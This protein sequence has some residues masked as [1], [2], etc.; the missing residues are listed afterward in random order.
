MSAVQ[1]EVVA[2]NPS[3]RLY[4]KWTAEGKGKDSSRVYTT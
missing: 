2:E 1:R 3:E 4:C